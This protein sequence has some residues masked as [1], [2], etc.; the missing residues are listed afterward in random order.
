[1]IDADPN[2]VDGGKIIEKSEALKDESDRRA[3]SAWYRVALAINE[4]P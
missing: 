2:V 3:R 4:T 1:M